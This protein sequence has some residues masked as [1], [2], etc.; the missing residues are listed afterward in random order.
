VEFLQYPAQAAV[1]FAWWL[2]MKSGE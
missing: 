2:M 1:G